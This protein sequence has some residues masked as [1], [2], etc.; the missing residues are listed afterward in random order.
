MASTLE[1]LPSASNSSRSQ[2]RLDAVKST[3]S[4]CLYRPN[5][6]SSCLVRGQSC[7]IDRGDVIVV[8]GL[9]TFPL[10]PALGPIHFPRLEVG[11]IDL[12]HPTVEHEQKVELELARCL[13]YQDADV[14]QGDGRDRTATP[15]EAMAS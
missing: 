1:R 11:D 15:A 3:R 14:V 9:G 12:S 4:A 5:C 10:D 2:G 13:A 6:S 8:V 7:I